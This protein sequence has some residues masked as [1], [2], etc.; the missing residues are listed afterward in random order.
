[1]SITNLPSPVHSEDPAKY[2]VEPARNRDDEIIERAL[3]ILR[4]RMTM[5][6]VFFTE[7]SMACDYARLK[8]AERKNEAF[9]AFWLDNR[10]GLIEFEELFHGTVDGSSVPPRVVVQR[11]LELNAVAVIFTHNHPSGNPEPSNAD[12][13]I[14]ERLR[15]AL[16][17]VDVRVLDH[18]VVGGP[19]TYSFAEQG[20]L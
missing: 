6:E 19:D 12:K 5:P 1:M 16:A 2:K 9:A 3:Q 14:T 8:L 11:A 10:H 15:D 4:A 20:L 17:L 18:I 13:R 7:P